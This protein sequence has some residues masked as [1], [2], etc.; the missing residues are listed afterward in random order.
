MLKKTPKVQPIP[1]IDTPDAANCRIP[2]DN[3]EKIFEDKLSMKRMTGSPML[4]HLKREY[5]PLTVTRT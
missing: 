1:E 2:N 3:L 5:K 4:I